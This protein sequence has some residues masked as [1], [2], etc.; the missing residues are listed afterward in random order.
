LVHQ[1]LNVQGLH[2]IR[3]ELH[4]SKEGH[5]CIRTRV[6]VPVHVRTRACKSRLSATTV[7]KQGRRFITSKR[8]W[9]QGVLALA[10]QVI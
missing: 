3:I 7:G 4:V 8:R 9:L 5:A 10:A 1:G 6:Y 2:D